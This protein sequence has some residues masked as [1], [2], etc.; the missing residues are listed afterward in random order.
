L[1]YRSYIIFKSDYYCILVYVF[2]MGSM[3]YWGGT[4]IT[5]LL[6]TV[7]YFGE[8]LVK[9]I[10]GGFAS[11][12]EPIGQSSLPTVMYPGESREPMVL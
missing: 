5:N 8:D 6:S 4:V 9:Y 7:P 2:P 10:W 11:F 1:I 3:S 12:E